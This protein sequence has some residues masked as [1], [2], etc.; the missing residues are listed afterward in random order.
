[1]M[2]GIHARVL[3]EGFDFARSAVIEFMD[4]LKIE[5]DVNDRELLVSVASASLRTKL[6]QALAD[7]VTDAVVDAVQCIRQPNMPI[8][9]HMVEIQHMQHMSDMDS[10]LVQGLV[11]DHGARHPAM[12][13]S[14][15]NCYI[16]TLNVSLEYEKSEVN[17]SFFWSDAS[18]RE[19][20]VTAERKF[21]D[22]RVKK[23]IEL[24]REVCDSEDKNFVV[25]NQKGIDPASLDMLHKAGIVALR[26]AKRR[27]M[28]RLTLSCGGMACNS[29]E[30][31]SPDVLGYAGHVY[32][33]TLGEEKYTFV[34]EVKN[35]QSC[36]LLIKG[37]NKYTI[38]QIKDAI[39]DGLRAVKNTIDDGAVLPGGGAFE[40]AAADHLRKRVNEVSGKA[41]LGVQA[42]ADALLVIPKVLAENSG[43]DAADSLIKLQEE[44][45][46][47]N[48]VGLDVNTGE[49]IDPE[50]IGVYDN[51]IV[52]RQCI[53][54]SA[55][56]TSQV[57]TVDAVIRA[58]IEKTRAPSVT[59]E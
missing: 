53:S 33:H 3:T 40:V 13:K 45:A 49:P 26:R 16:L 36:T 14:V 19:K 11:L 7:K 43:F 55:V 56:I 44:Y 32:E 52:K 51:F 6:H 46:K 5:K 10:R 38:T 21:T 29:V 35:P 12:P 25:I 4:Q 42:F 22:D 15:K 58:G 41:K 34:E 2:E 59:G 30:D 48:I 37:P 27:N 17:S 23:I 28:E 18:Q 20:L 50:S 1:M 24:K 39:R 9:L 8:D 31:L 54:G 47:G 57:L